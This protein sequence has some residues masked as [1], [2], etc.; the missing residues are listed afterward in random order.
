MVLGVIITIMSLAVPSLIGLG[1][2][3]KAKESVGVI[4]GILNQARLKASSQNAHTFVAFRE[5][6]QTVKMIYF[7]SEDGDDPF[8]SS[9]TPGNLAALDLDQAGDKLMLL[10]RPAQFDNTALRDIDFTY[11]S[12]VLRQNGASTILSTS[13]EVVY[14][15]EKYDRIIQFSPSGELRIDGVE[16]ILVE[17]GIQQLRNGNAGQFY[18]VIQIPGTTGQAFVYSN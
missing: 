13:R 11:P 8:L 14:R 1:S 5:A 6:G 2:T 17:F 16:Q 10:D 12:S 7:R 15:G 4:A 18:S 9:S 3:W